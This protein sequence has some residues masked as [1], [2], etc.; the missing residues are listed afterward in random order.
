MLKIDAGSGA[1]VFAGTVDDLWSAKAAAIFGHRFGGEGFRV[2]AP[3]M[4]FGREVVVGVVSDEGFGE[5]VWLDEEE[6]MFVDGRHLLVDGVEDV[7]GGD[8]VED[9]GAGD[10]L[11][12]VEQ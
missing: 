11:R 3:T 9:G 1:I 12:M 4:E 5:V 8:D 10:S 7:V 2:C 6:P